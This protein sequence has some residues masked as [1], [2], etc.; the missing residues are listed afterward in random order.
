MVG[1]LLSYW[2]GHDPSREK[3]WVCLVRHLG[4]SPEIS[5]QPSCWGS[6][7]G[8]IVTL[9]L[10]IIV[11][12]IRGVCPVEMIE[13]PSN[14][15]KSGRHM[16]ISKKL[17]HFLRGHPME[18]GHPCPQ[19]NFLDLSVEW[20]DLMNFMKQKIWNLE[21]WE[22]LQV[23]RSSDS[24]RFQIQVAKRDGPEATWKG[25]PWIPVACRT[26]QGHNRALMKEAKIGSMV[27]ELYTLDTKFNP[28]ALDLLGPGCASVRRIRLCS[29]NFPSTTVAI[30]PLSMRSSRMD[31]FQWGGQNPAAD[32]TT[33]SSWHH[34][35]M[36]TWGS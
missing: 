15:N 25:L 4:K 29:R 1:I 20:G 19:C 23:V 6:E 35:G 14:V 9:D 16:Q 22:V 3:I 32:F 10:L 13:V 31:W 28:E 26:F 30:V 8:F 36:P 21:G 12:T 18:Y 24:R 33:I 11:L 2:G 27:K 7:T 5:D 17:S 34:H